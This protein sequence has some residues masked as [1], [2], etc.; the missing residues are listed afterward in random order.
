MTTKDYQLAAYKLNQFAW[1]VRN[2]RTGFDMAKLAA[3]IS[4]AG[5]TK[6]EIE[7]SLRCL[8]KLTS[9]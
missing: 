4:N 1:W 2:K 5:F 7:K 8:S 6:E 9:K 3:A